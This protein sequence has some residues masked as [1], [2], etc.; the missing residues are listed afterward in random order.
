[1]P[2]EP[3][4]RLAVGRQRHRVRVPQHQRPPDLALEAADVLADGR[5]L[6]AEPDRGAGEAAGLLD[7]EERREQLRIISR[8]NDS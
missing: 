6:D 7:R 5:L 2:R 4:H 8:H 1:M 3:D